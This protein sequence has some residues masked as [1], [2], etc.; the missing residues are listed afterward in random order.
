MD[1]YRGGDALNGE[2]MGENL[3]LYDGEYDGD[4]GEYDGDVGEYDGDVGEYDGD[5][6]EYDG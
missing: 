5:V 2:F 1:A 3:A 6:G 4:V